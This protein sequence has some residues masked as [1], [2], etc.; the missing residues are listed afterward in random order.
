MAKT[1]DGSRSLLRVFASVD[2][3]AMQQQRRRL[4][5]TQDSISKATSA[6][7]T[8]SSQHSALRLD[9]GDTTMIMWMTVMKQCKSGIRWKEALPC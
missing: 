2:R 8:S 3:C 7:V 5:M 4:S 1:K 6:P 9:G